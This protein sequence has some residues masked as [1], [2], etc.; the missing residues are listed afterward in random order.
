MIQM[1]AW[2][3]DLVVVNTATVPSPLAAARLMKIPAV[4]LIRETLLTNPSLR[5]VLPRSWIRRVL[6]ILSTRAIL[7]SEFAAAQYGYP[8]RVVYPPVRRA[9]VQGSGNASQRVPGDPLEIVMM[10]SLTPDKGQLDAITAVALAREQGVRLR[11]RLYGTG[12][13]RDVLDVER[14]ISRMGLRDVAT[15]EGP[16]TSPEVVLAEADVSLVCS[17]NEAYGKV[18]VE[19]LLSGTPVIGYGLGGTLE[20][21]RHGGGILTAPAPESMADAIVQICRDG[22]LDD[23][24]QEA[25][26]NRAACA[27]LTSDRTLADLVVSTVSDSR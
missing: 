15:Y 22:A 6:N 1:R 11:M 13:P 14:H 5:S 3:P 24:R 8:A 20:I 10:G 16:T 23:L 7:N 4:L 27:S 2:N 12:T 18:T 26:S 9:F 25:V 21:L 19:S 17:R